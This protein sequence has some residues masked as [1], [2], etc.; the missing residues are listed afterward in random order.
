MASKGTACASAAVLLEQ[1]CEMLTLTCA[2]EL[3]A[4]LEKAALLTSQQT[5]RSLV[6]QVCNNWPDLQVAPPND[7]E[8]PAAEL[9]LGVFV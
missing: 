9:V 7:L 2:L 3:R 6:E 5:A 8:W 4:A 1:A